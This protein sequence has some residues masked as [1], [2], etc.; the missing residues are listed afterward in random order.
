MEITAALMVLPAQALV[1]QLD[2]YS[3]SFAY[4]YY[5]YNLRLFSK[6]TFPLLLF[7]FILF[8]IFY[9]SYFSQTRSYFFY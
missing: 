3:I 4:Y 2:E 1:S 5:L 9:I 8:F 6:I 7:Y